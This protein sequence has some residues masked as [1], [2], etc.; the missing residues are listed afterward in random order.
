M[1]FFF[2]K[3]RIVVDV[4]TT[5][6]SVYELYKPDVAVKF[7]PDI[8]KSLPNSYEKVDEQTKITYKLSTIR[9]CNGV[10][11]YYKT[12][13]MIPMWTD[14]I[15][16]PK[17]AL[18]HKTAIAMVN[19]PFYYNSHDREQ[20]GDL[21]KDH[22]HVKLSSPWAFREKSGVKFYWNAATWNL[23]NHSNNF[24]VLPAVISFNY[25]SQTN[26]NIFVKNNSNNFIINSGTPLVHLVPIT[27]NK[28]VMKHHLVDEQEYSKIGI[29]SDY[30]AI[31]PGRY[32]RWIK[33][34][35][36]NS[37]KCPFGFRK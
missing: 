27:E 16:E 7:Y 28:V 32:N 22:F 33:E 37:S 12:G 10:I 17:N 13:F 29:P 9:K 31:R 35:T 4:F 11:D 34:K 30:S 23:D 14:F 6:R 36:E 20:Y 24:V 15:C 1:F 26:V 5:L 18:E 21:Y 3:K 19:L 2:K 25:Q 8:V